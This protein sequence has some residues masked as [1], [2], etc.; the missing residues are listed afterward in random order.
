MIISGDQ[1]RKVF[2]KLSYAGDSACTVWP[3]A[4]LFVGT[5]IECPM[6]VYPVT[7]LLKVY[8]FA[9]VLRVGHMYAAA[10]NQ[11]LMKDRATKI[12]HAAVRSPTVP[13]FS[14]VGLGQICKTV[15]SSTHKT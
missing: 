15:Y 5:L 10:S 6:L 3:S 11:L 7:T 8:T 9:K 4:T 2:P 13:S 12:T 1:G 14:R